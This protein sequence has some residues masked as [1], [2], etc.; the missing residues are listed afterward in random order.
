[1]DSPSKSVSAL[2]A[3]SLAQTYR[4]AG[5]A[6]PTDL[7]LRFRTERAHDL[8]SLV[9]RYEG[10]PLVGPLLGL[11]QLAGIL[12]RLEHDPTGL[13]IY[14]PRELPRGWLETLAELWGSPL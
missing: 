6:D 1:M 2:V 10:D 11:S 13:T 12:E 14:W 7:V 4:A 5:S 9:R 3:T 8:D